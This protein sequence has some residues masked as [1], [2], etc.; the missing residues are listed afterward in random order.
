MPKVSDLLGIVGSTF[1]IG[2]RSLAAGLRR[3]AFR[4]GAFLGAVDWTPTAN[5]T[6]V[7]PDDSVT[8][9]G[10][11]RPIGL[12][13][14]GVSLRGYE[15]IITVTAT[16]TLAMADSG[17]VQNCTNA[18]AAIVTIPLNSAVAFPIGAKVIVRKTTAQTVT[19]DWSVGVTVLNSL[20]AALTVT[21][22]V[23][24]AILRKTGT[25]AWIATLDPPESAIG[26]ALRT[27]VD[28]PSAKSTIGLS[29]V[30]NVLLTETRSVGLQIGT[31]STPNNTTGAGWTAIGRNAA[32]AST[33][34]NS[35]VAIGDESA[36]TNSTGNN[37]VAI[38][39]NAAFNSSSG[40]GWVA[41]GFS[42]GSS[43]LG[44]NWVAIGSSTGQD[45]TTGSSN[46]MIGANTGRGV[47]TGSGNTIV[48]AGVIGLAAALANNV[49]LASGDGV[50]KLQ[51]DS[52]GL[53]TLPINPVF[54]DNSTLVATTAHVKNLLVNSPS[55]TLTVLRWVSGAFLGSLNW[56]PTAARTIT[57]PDSSGT[58]QL[59]GKS[60]ATYRGVV[61]VTATKTLVL[62][63]AGTYQY[64]TNAAAITVTIPTNATAAFAIGSAI[65]VK[66]GGAGALSIAI[67]AGV[68]LLRDNGATLATPFT[69]TKNAELKKVAVD[70]WILEGA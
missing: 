57:L 30:T 50:I 27:A 26:A 55:I 66:K 40:S 37:W 21:G 13:N 54:S 63:D 56:V 2:S 53:A 24:V 4:S 29:L 60:T 69:L 70:S 52:T 64:C 47:T 17:T 65:E 68:I 45:V 33:S 31:G 1:T 62:G 41:I 44:N 22:V 28:A 3:L 46:T 48:G 20:G 11:D 67:I 42:A 35:W 34:G 36:I 38:G 32:Q 9:L 6:I 5:R 18:A 61:T 14:A 10:D 59:D 15:P 25:D 23:S 43:T 39:D 12:L 58:V 8:L 16:K 19:I 51:I 49:I 7:L